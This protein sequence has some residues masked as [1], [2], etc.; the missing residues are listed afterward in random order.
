MKKIIGVLFTLAMLVNNYTMAQQV[1]VNIGSASGNVGD[2]VSIPITVQLPNGSQTLDNATG[3]IK[4]NN[5]NVAQIVSSTQIPGV[6]T[7]IVQ[8]Q[9]NFT[10][11]G[12]S[13]LTNG[14]LM[15]I[16][17]QILDVGCTT[18][19]LEEISKNSGVEFTVNGVSYSDLGINVISN[20]GQVCNNCPVYIQEVRLFDNSYNNVS[21]PSIGNYTD[22]SDNCIPIFDTQFQQI[23]VSASQGNVFMAVYADADFDGVFETVL[24]NS[25]DSN[26]GIGVN[27][28]LIW[29][30]SLPVRVIVSDQ[31]I[32]DPAN[33]PAC[34]EVEDYV[35]CCSCDISNLTLGPISYEP[36]SEDCSSYVINIPPVT[37]CSDV[38]VSHNYNFKIRNSDGNLVY[39]I[40]T[41]DDGIIY[42]FPIAGT[43]R[44]IITYTI[45]D[46][47]GCEQT[48]Q[49]Q[50][51]FDFE[52]CEDCTDECFNFNPV[53]IL[54]SNGCNYQFIA[55]WQT[56]GK[57]ENLTIISENW[58]F[59][60][61]TQQSNT[62]GTPIQHSFP[63]N[64]LYTVSLT[65]T[66]E[67]NGETFTTCVQELLV[68]VNGC[69]DCECVGGGQLIAGID[70]NC[71]VSL[72]ILG[73]NITNCLTSAQFNWD[74]GDGNTST[75]STPSA[76][77]QYSTPGIYFPTVSFLVSDPAT[78]E[79]C[80][81]TYVTRVNANCTPNED[82][83][84]TK[85]AQLNTTVE[86]QIRTNELKLSMYPNPTQNSV[87]VTLNGI[88]GKTEL[89]QPQILIYD[90][91]GREVYRSDIRLNEATTID[92]SHFKSGIYIAKIT[93][94]AS[95][96]SAEKLIIE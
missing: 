9:L 12:P 43:Y 14:W 62:W 64:G 68:P 46:D 76:G 2:I 91:T 59:G 33:I 53:S 25:F 1:D 35:L 22:Y 17:V 40:N 82:P 39:E 41:T 49:Y 71:N 50:E 85:S 67:V 96:L 89:L 3:A 48:I 81:Q 90:M 83:K 93:N 42:D 94:D 75:T 56:S 51:N 7:A 72:S 52:D 29:Q 31:A 63:G 79:T 16:N 69:K 32:T 6:N 23:N 45:I 61:G 65:V 11:L 73:L 24:Y 74:F 77:H 80:T 55:D 86:T 13:T 44:I 19:Y 27:N 60:D 87:T 21:G 92:I 78:G 58:H 84:R 54:S 88:S 5:P 20:D 10:H 4:L 15:T 38:E 37:G 18:I 70:I 57:C 26:G 47:S 95:T 8:D 34:G 66:Y 36:N 28:S 30:G